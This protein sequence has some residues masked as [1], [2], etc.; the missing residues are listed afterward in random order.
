MSNEYRIDTSPPT[1][2]L[3]I[4]R[5]TKIAVG[6]FRKQGDPS[7]MIATLQAMLHAFSLEWKHDQV[8]IKRRTRYQQKKGNKE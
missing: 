6:A 3:V 5:K 8:K 4:D 7:N 2:V 1:K